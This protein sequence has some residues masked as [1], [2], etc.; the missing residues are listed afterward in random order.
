MAEE[1]KKGCG[2]GKKNAA[3]EPAREQFRTEV[4]TNEGVTEIKKNLTMVQNFASAIASRGLTNKKIGTSEKQLRVLSCFGNAHLGGQLPPCEHLKKSKTEG[5]YFC[6]GCG[7]GD[8]PRTWLLAEGEEYSK[9]DYPKL[10]CPLK[11]PGFSNY[12]KSTP[13]EAIPP[14]TRRFYIENMPIEEVNK[15]PVTSPEIPVPTQNNE[16]TEE[17]KE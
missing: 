14:I 1:Q 3:T 15:I 9:L 7:C 4:K 6:G 16:K 10:S 13:D 8:K 12:E 2:C 17:K 11:M 5:K